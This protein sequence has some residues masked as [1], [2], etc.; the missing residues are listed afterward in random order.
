[1]IRKAAKYCGTFFSTA[2]QPAI[3][4]ISVMNVV[5]RISGSAMPSM[6]SAYSAPSVSIQGRRSTNCIAAVV[7]SNP[8]Y[9]GRLT[10]KA[11]AATAIAVTRAAPSPQ[12]P[13]TSVA[14][15]PRIGSQMTSESSGSIGHSSPN[16]NGRAAARRSR[17]RR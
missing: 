11:A 12:R 17:A 2:P 15:P 13:A 8:V 9:S 5:S 14:T 6:P 10:R 16:I 3:T 4:T 1:M 7:R